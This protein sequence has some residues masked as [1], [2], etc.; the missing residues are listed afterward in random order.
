MTDY[1]NTGSSDIAKEET[2]S[3]IAASKVEGT[4]VYD[5]QGQSLGSVYDVMIDKRSGEVAY[6]VMSFGGFLGMGQS[7]HPLPWDVLDYDEARGG[8]VVDLDEERL[9][10]AP[11]YDDTNTPNWSSPEFGRRIDEYYGVTR[12]EL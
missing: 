4:N 5:R 7:Y 9:T 12:S 2:G 10:N 8:Y 1:S 11:H 3:L 6:A